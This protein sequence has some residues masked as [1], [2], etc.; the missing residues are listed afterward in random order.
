[1]KG[2]LA[3][4]GAAFVWATASLI[5]ARLGKQK[6]SPL[7]MNLVK[8]TLALT[9]MSITLF[10]QN[11]ILWPTQA[12][13]HALLYLGI[14]GII[15]LSIG[16]TSY[17]HALKRIGARRT[18]LL[19]T[20]G[21]PAT[22]IMAWPILHEPITLPMLAGMTLTLFGV[23]W[24]ISEQQATTKDTQDQPEESPNSEQNKLLIHGI[25]FAGIAV[26][27]QA[28]GN[29]LTKLGSAPNLKPLE[30]GMIRL[31]FGIVGLVL[32]VVLSRKAGDIKHAFSKKKQAALLLLA[33]FLGTYLG[34]WLL[35]ASLSWTKVGIAATLSATSPLFVLPLAALFTGERITL[36][37]LIGTVIS[38]VGVAI[39]TLN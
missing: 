35:M 16:D 38:I 18:L 11:R 36:R 2:E 4:L 33:A 21:P 31:T 17:F 30:I 20:L 8:C 37:A 32:V 1:M 3:A 9:L 14:S 29:V 27:C 19:S 25:I 28:L 10:I 13:S 23:G 22:A 15:G 5:F 7:A 39:L 34:I 6:L 26:F 24:V 12:P